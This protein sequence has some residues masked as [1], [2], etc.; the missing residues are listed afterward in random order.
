MKYSERIPVFF[1]LSF[2]LSIRQNELKCF[3]RFAKSRDGKK[4]VKCVDYVST[5]DC[6]VVCAVSK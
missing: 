3:G 2:P 1:P 6:K 5:P 4:E